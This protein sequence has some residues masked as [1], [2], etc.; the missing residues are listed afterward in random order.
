[1]HTVRQGESLWDISVQ[2]Y[3]DGK[4][5]KV[6]ADANRIENPDRIYEGQPIQLLPLEDYGTR[7]GD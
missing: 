2:T 4:Y 6:L 3:G 1:M 7:I 5:A